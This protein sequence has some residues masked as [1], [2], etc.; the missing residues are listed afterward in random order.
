MHSKK[1]KLGLFGISHLMIDLVGIYILFY[2]YNHLSFE[3]IA[4]YFI[5]YNLLAFGMQVV[6]GYYAD[7]NNLYKVYLVLPFLL[8]SIALLLHEKGVG[9]VLIMTLANA[10]IHVGGGVLSVDMYKGKSMPA[11]VFVAPGVIGVFLGGFLALNELSVAFYLLPIVVLL[12]IV[13]YL[14]VQT[15]LH[16]GESGYLS[17]NLLKLVG[18]IL[19]IIAVRA[20]LGSL[21]IMDWNQSSLFQFY[22]VLSVFLG[23]FLGGILGDRFGFKKVGVYGLMLSA[24]FLIIGRHYI[25]FGLVG[26]FLFNLT[27]A[28]T[29]F[30]IMDILKPFK[31][32]AFGLTTLTLVIF[33]MPSQ[34]GLEISN[35]LFYYSVVVIGV[36]GAAYVL[37]QTLKI[38]E[39]R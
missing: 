11:G 1:I 29:L 5:I 28:I 37:N 22:L 6:F 14:V 10:M 39:R 20:F 38:Y 32:F 2:Q 23:K 7:K 19:I 9:P 26:A 12:F 31:G 21:F 24:P 8:A 36:L 25:I 33:V 3:H 15:H 16:I 17:G 18:F 35:E 34:L 13:N 4:L 27:M 30:L